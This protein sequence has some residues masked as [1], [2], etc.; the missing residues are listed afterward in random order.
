M[1]ASRCPFAA[2]AGKRDAVAPAVAGEEFAFLDE[3]HA[4]RGDAF[5]AARRAECAAAV[6]RGL[7]APLDA[8]ELTWA[9]RIGW[10]NHARCIGRLHWRSLQVRDRRGVATA[11]ELIDCL[12]GHLRDA[13]GDGMVKPIMTVLAGGVGEGPVPRIRNSQ[14]CG[15]AGYRAA[16]GTVL[17]DPKNSATTALAL[18][19]GWQPPAER[20]RFDLLPWIVRGAEG[21]WVL[22]PL[23]TGLV[24]EVRLRHPR[25]GWFEQ[26][27]LRW[28]A[29]PVVCDLGLHA[30]GTFFPTAPFN[31]WYMGTEIGARNLADTDRYDQLPVIADRLGL[32]RT[33]SCPLWRD[34]ALL[35]LNE[36]VLHSYA[37]DGVKLVD[38]H[39]ASEEFMRFCAHEQQEGREVSARWDWIV[40]PLS[41]AT[42]RVYHQ[43]MRELVRSPDFLP[44]QPAEA[45]SSLPGT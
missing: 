26:L 11:P 31:G 1:S 27:G 29:V 18:Q 24:R 34:R 7:P 2:S 42:T 22:A 28:Y 32:P 35:E 14:L 8:H 23:P 3:A 19:L 9:A 17:G 16:D 10:R 43:P 15:Y 41:P 21:P 39:A 20:S 5:V 33:R 36:A 44:A 37:A 38:H 25:F 13:Q 12:R 6:A 30:A 45:Q 4:G 40:P